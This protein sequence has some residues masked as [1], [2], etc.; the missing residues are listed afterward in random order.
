[1]PGYT[2]PDG[3]TVKNKLG[4]TSV[5]EL[6][7][8]EPNYVVP[9][10]FQIELGHGPRGQFDAVHLKAIHRHL[11]QDVFEW[12]GHTRDER[13]K[14]ADGTVASEPVLRKQGG[15]DFLNAHSFLAPSTISQGLCVQPTTCAAL[16]VKNF[17]HTRPTLWPRS[18]RP[19]PS[20]TEMA[21]HS[22]PS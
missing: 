21:A 4:A 1:V 12:A 8:L 16:R 18:T 17:L 5:A 2:L 9:R 20:A 19:I 22:G 15:K 6:A 14:L 10:Q 7:R 13:V 11:F 3:K